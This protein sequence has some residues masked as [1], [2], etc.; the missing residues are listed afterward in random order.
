M[1][2]P[3]RD[4]GE[5]EADHLLVWPRTSSEHCQAVHSYIVWISEELALAG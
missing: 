5:E 2:L 4:Q 3:L 1:C